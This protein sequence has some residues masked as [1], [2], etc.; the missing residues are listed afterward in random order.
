MA[1]EQKP[2]DGSHYLTIIA[3]S[4]EEVMRQYAAR[5]LAGLGYAILGPIVPH[6][7]ALIDDGI[8]RELF[9]GTP[10]L[11]ATFVRCARRAA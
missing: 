3:G 10:M 6:R 7:F 11:A 9:G 5:G 8:S 2:A 1:P 4:A